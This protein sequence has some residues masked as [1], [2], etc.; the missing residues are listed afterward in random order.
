VAN[1]TATGTGIQWY[2]TPT[3]GTAL[4]GTT[5]L[6]T[7]TTYYASQT[8][9]SCES[10]T[11]L[12]VT[13][14]ITAPAAPTGPAAQAFCNSGTVAN[15][16]ATGTGIQWY[17][18]PTGGTALSGTTALTT[19]T[20]YFASQTLSGCESANRLA[21]TAALVPQPTATI[22]V[23]GPVEYCLGEPIS[24]LFQLTNVVPSVSTVQWFRNGQPIS[25][26]TS[27]SLMAS[28]T[29]YYAAVLA[30]LP[31]CTT[32][33]AGDTIEAITPPT[34]NPVT[35]PSFSMPSDTLT[36]STLGSTGAPIVWTV[37]GG[38]LLSGQGTPTIDVIW[39]ISGVV[40]AKMQVGPC[41][42]TD[43]LNVRVSGIGIDEP[44]PEEIV[45]VYPN[46]TDGF[47]Q[48][49]PWHDGDRI[50]VYT[51][52]GKR[53]EVPQ[54]AGKLDLTDWP[55]GVYQVLVEGPDGRIKSRHRLV[56]Q[57]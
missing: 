29:G 21:V 40:E 45:Q 53:L 17:A 33:V 30:T 8:L 54:T 39:L 22:V 57:K 4:S 49:F 14:T 55:A 36:Y 43:T 27:S 10:A 5:A 25:N 20:T 16:T 12:A 41:I 42:R 6:T 26:Q 44:R 3:G 7:G 13:A 31:G 19:G 11:R 34:L 47:T 46:P 1:L 18:T 9:S 15:L 56:L 24:T 23:A 35:G 38:V 51:V 2:S 52:D 28:Q 32:T 48:I 37:T 50:V